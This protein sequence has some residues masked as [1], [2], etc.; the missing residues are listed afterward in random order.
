MLLGLRVTSTAE[1]AMVMTELARLITEHTAL[2]AVEPPGM[3]YRNK[4]VSIVPLMKSAASH[5]SRCISLH[6]VSISRTL[7]IIAKR[8]MGTRT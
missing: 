5:A 8:T 1:D 6:H 3:I 4:V 2:M 7:K